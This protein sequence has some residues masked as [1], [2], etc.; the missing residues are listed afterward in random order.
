MRSFERVSSSVCVWK[1]E[2]V[3]VYVCL[4]VCVRACKCVLACV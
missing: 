2:S 3:N 1:R 4:C